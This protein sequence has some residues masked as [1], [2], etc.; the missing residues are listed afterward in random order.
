MPN[1]F[2]LPGWASP[3]KQTP[4][5][6][7][8]SPLSENNQTEPPT[9]TPTQDTSASA[10]SLASQGNKL[11]TETHPLPDTA[12]EYITHT[13]GRN[14]TEEN[15]IQ[16]IWKNIMAAATESGAT[17]ILFR[18][19]TIHLRIDKLVK[20]WARFRE[21]TY[22]ALIYHHFA[23]EH[24][25]ILE[26]QGELDHAIEVFGHRLRANT[27]KTHTGLSCA[28]RPLRDKA[29]PWNENGLSDAVI[30]RLR[31]HHNGLILVTGPTGSGKS[32]TIC[33]MIEFLNETR[34]EHIITIED[35]IEYVFTEK[36]CI[37]D[38]REVGKHTKT[39]ES[40]LRAAMRENPD[41][42]FVGEIRD[43]ETADIAL[44][45]AETGHLVFATL[46]TTRVYQ[47]ISRLLAMVPEE[48]IK[49]IRNLLSNNLVM[50][51]CQ[52]LLPRKKGGLWPAREVMFMNAAIGNLIRSG[53]EKQINT[54][55]L[56][57]IADGMMEWNKCLQI[58]SSSN[59]ISA[60]IATSYEE[61]GDTI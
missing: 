38:Q 14:A 7:P 48:R 2:S 40:A 47:T 51:M 18:K 15:E 59:I 13:S 6:N 50:V 16:E 42:I 31:N 56:S 29:I 61:N 33:S 8:I 39:F 17:D 27:Y 41:I 52:R 23:K 53:G 43:Y 30:E 28:Y 37:I 46:H 32:T 10:E 34:H 11:A 3:R 22:T 4:N 25:H 19:N 45:A 60:A 24:H 36:N 26:T 20:P 57:G 21:D 1:Q 55:L 49:E 9:K 54:Y 35:P 12:S 5:E 44:R 58:A